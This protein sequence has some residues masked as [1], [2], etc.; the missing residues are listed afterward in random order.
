M[1]TQ[2]AS[3]SVYMMYIHTHTTYIASYYS[4][5]TDCRTSDRIICTYVVRAEWPKKRLEEENLENCIGGCPRWIL[6][7][8]AYLHVRI[9]MYIC[10]YPSYLAPSRPRTKITKQGST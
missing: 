5:T 2:V 6:F 3:Q 1:K 8:V 7:P 4:S 9:P 10:T